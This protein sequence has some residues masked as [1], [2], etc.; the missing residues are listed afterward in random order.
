LD[1]PERW[2]PGFNS[3]SVAEVE[4]RSRRELGMKLPRDFGVPDELSP[5]IPPGAPWFSIWTFTQAQALLRAG[6]L[7]E[8]IARLKSG[9]ATAANLTLPQQIERGLAILQGLAPR[10]RHAGPLIASARRSLAEIE[11]SVAR[12]LVIG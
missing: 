3:L 8:S 7:D 12:H 1:D 2:T 4:L 9:L 11:R 5:G 6:E 10:S